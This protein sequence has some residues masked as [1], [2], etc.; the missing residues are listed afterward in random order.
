MK[1]YSTV[2]SFAY[3]SPIVHFPCKLSL[4]LEVVVVGGVEPCVLSNM[5]GK[6]DFCHIL[7]NRSFLYEMSYDFVM[8]SFWCSFSHKFDKKM[9]LEDPNLKNKRLFV[10]VETKFYL[11]LT[12]IADRS[13]VSGLLDLP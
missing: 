2:F 9:F 7:S 8:T 11:T 5:L 12:G 3:A 10:V 4:M 6:K 1:S 13:S